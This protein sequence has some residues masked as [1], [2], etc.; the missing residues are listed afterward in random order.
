MIIKRSKHSKLS[1]LRG[2]SMPSV[3]LKVLLHYTIY[4]PIATV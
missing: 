4:V 1:N 2:H 3:R